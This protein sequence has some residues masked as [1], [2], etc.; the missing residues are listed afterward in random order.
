MS[1]TLI[2]KEFAS[3]LQGKLTYVLLTI[4]VA[5]FTGLILAAFWLVVVSVP[6]LVPVIG[7]SASGSSSLTLA[8]LIAGNRGAFLFYGLAISLLAAVF[9]VAPAVAAASIAGERENDTLDLLL[10]TGIRPR[11]IVIGKLAANI[12]FVGLLACTTLPGFAIAWMFGG[13]SGRD[14]G[15]AL[16]VLLASVTFISAVGVFFSAV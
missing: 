1:S 7:S 14:V 6:T 3:R 12:L 11:S 4:M 9:A 15:L 8:A 5:I 13:V 10:V 16:A 2:G